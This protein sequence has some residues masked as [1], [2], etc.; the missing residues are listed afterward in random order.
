MLGT[1]GEKRETATQLWCYSIT[2]G[3]TTKFSH[4][5]VS[6]KQGCGSGPGFNDLVDPDSES[7]SLIL[8]KA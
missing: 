2:Y 4:V 1:V 6:L 7:G 3:T 8:E 5:N